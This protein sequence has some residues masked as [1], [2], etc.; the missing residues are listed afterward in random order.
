MSHEPAGAG[1]T[2]DRRL[3]DLNE[4]TDL[5]ALVELTAFAQSC[6]GAD[7]DP[8]ADARALEITASTQPAAGA[9]ADPRAEKHVGFDHGIRPDFRIVAEGD[10]F[11]RDKGHARVHD[12][13]PQPLLQPSLD[14]GQIGANSAVGKHG[15]VTC[16]A[17]QA[18][19][20]R[21]NC[22]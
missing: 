20:W 16:A 19:A 3:L 10:G 22:R 4:V 5:D 9:D 11:R 13:G 12:S 15:S 14:G 17:K 2:I 7:D 1:V 8:F 18:D 21:N 6:H